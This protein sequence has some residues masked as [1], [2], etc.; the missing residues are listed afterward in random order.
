MA[1]II[2]LVALVQL[3]NG[4]AMDARERDEVK[5]YYEGR[6]VWGRPMKENKVAETEKVVD[7]IFGVFESEETTSIERNVEP[8]ESEVDAPDKF[9]E[10]GAK[11]GLPGVV[12]D[13]KSSFVDYHDDLPVWKVYTKLQEGQKSAELQT[14]QEQEE[15]EKRKV[16]GGEISEHG[17]ILASD[18]LPSW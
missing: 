11:K 13:Q 9:N 12:P 14:Q 15:E 17:T 10:S 4:R 6:P 2:W 7:D 8:W 5:D 3:G 18:A 1:R 16:E